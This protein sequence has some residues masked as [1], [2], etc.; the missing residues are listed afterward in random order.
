MRQPSARIAEGRARWARPSLCL[1]TGAATLLACGLISVAAGA[2][3]AAPPAPILTGTDPESPGLSLTPVVHGSSDG[4]IKSSFPGVRTGAIGLAGPATT[5]Y[6]Y[7]NKTCEGSAFGSA[8]ATDFD[9]SGIQV[10]V[11]PETTTWISANVEDEVEGFSPCSNA[12]AY[13]QVKELP[14][15]EE[16]PPGGGG[17][18]SGNNS[19]G[20]T[21][22]T[23]P[24]PPRLRL[25]PSGLANSTIPTVAGSAPGASLVRLYDVANCSGTPL[26]KVSPGQLA[27]GV[28]V[29]VLPN[30]ITAFSAVSVGAGGVSG[31]SA[32]AYYTEDSIRPRTRI[33]M[34]PASKTRRRVAVFRFID[35]TGTL[36]GTRFFCRVNRAKWKSCSSPMRISNLHPRKYVFRVKAVDP[37]GNGDAKPARRSFKVVPAP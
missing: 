4:V 23:P 20:G 1:R 12:I 19:G 31:C 28:P 5:V 7:P 37:A 14:H 22:L 34:G 2:A 35:T 36:P 13:Q 15:K 33:T 25:L 17:G 6:L 9:T 16:P 3:A 18:G 26:I 21:P 29:R 10:T 24:A 27:G 32:P 30:A 8:L 11:E